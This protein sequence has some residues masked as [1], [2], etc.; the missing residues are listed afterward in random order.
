ME[1][2]YKENQEVVIATAR[3]G[4]D[5]ED[6]IATARGGEDKEDRSY[7]YSKRW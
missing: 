6:L 1:L 2:I 7:S 5:K 3:G 4:E